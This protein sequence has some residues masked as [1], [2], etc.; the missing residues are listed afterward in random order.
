MNTWLGTIKCHSF[1]IVNMSI[2]VC[3]SIIVPFMMTLLEQVNKQVA[4]STFYIISYNNG[5]AAMHRFPSCVG[6]VYAC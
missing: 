3:W 5:G 6:S 1:L 2:E 4:F